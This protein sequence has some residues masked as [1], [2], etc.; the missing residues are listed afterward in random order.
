MPSIDLSKNEFQHPHPPALAMH[1]L[2]DENAIKH[3]PR[4]DRLRQRLAQ[5]YGV[6]EESLFI[7]PGGATALASVFLAYSWSRNGGAGTVLLPDMT[8][9]YYEELAERVGCAVRPFPIVRGAGRYEFDVETICR[10][11]RVH[12]DPLV[13]LT[14]PN[15]P[16]GSNLTPEELRT[17][18]S[19]ASEDAVLLID[20]VYHGFGPAAFDPAEII[21]AFPNALVLRTFSKLYGLAGVR[22]AYLM[23][24]SA[25]RARLR[26]VQPYLGMSSVAERIALF[27]LDNQ[28]YYERIAAETVAE[29]DR[30]FDFLNT[31]DCCECFRSD[32]NFLL[33]HMPGLAQD[34]VSFLG[35]HGVAVR[36][37]K[38]GKLADHVR[39]TIGTA[40]QM[41]IVHAL[42]AQFAD[43]HAPQRAADLQSA[44]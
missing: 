14:V 38:G 24:G 28:D 29:R 39:V 40:S 13:V 11:L 20:G 3:Y 23:A 18:C 8:W 6:G 35:R 26:L 2:P 10:L 9:Q 42:T 5:L 21:E 27:C 37:F 15:N 4:S 19:A 31:L 16:S 34:Y 41:Q 30:L 22:V 7:Q 44:L 33:M 1:G 12:R 43:L 36:P 32:A 17:V 25:A